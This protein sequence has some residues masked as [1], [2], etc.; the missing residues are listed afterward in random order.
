MNIMVMESM[1]ERVDQSVIKCFRHMER[2][3][4]ERLTKRKYRGRER[5]KKSGTEEVKDLVKLRSLNFQENKR[6]MNRNT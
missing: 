4:D 1:F 6:T 5:L 3:D 2:M